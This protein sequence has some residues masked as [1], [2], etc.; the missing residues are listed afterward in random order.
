MV[1]DDG[2]QMN[3]DHA[4]LF[5]ICMLSRC[6]SVSGIFLFFIRKAAFPSRVR[7]YNP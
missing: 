3:T 6:L 2:T 1:K 5:N 7:P 4:D